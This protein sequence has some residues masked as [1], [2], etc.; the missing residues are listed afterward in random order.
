MADEPEEALDERIERIQRR[1]ENFRELLRDGDEV[2][3]A[4]SEGEVHVAES[5]RSQ[6]ERKHAK[7]FGRMLSIEAQMETG[8]SPY[9]AALVLTGI[10]LFGLS[11]GWWDGVLGE[12][13]SS[14]LNS[15]WFYIVLPPALLYL[16]RVC[17]IRWENFVYR[18][19][20]RELVD[21]IAAEKLD[22]DVLLVMLRDEDDLGNIVY[23]L[24]LDAGPFPHPAA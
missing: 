6:F 15:W 20:R 18:R 11:I 12:T 21:L 23:K 4:F 13:V 5:Y 24:K 7:L 16:G 10:I 9:F 14:A 19:N 8:L 22:R 1:A 3:I 17:C 2:T